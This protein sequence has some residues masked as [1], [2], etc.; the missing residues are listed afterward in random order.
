MAVSKH[1]PLDLLAEAQ[2]AGQLLFGEN[3][4]QEAQSKIGALGGGAVWHCIGHLQSNKARLAAELFDW[5]E[6]VDRLKLAAA[7]DARLAEL[8]RIMPVLIQVNLAGEEQKS[9]LRPEDAHGSLRISMGKDNTEE[10]VKSFLE[11]LPK[12]VSNLRAMSPYNE[13]NPMKSDEPWCS[14][15]DEHDH[16]HGG[17]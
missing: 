8:S 17:E 10:D 4:L 16:G 15:E 13:K 9:G 1:Q 14:K 7:L 11:T 3:Y 12:V 2:A 5:I 6:T